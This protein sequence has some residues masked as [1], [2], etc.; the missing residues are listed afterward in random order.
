MNQSGNYEMDLTKKESKPR[1][2]KQEEDK[3][4]RL[5]EKYRNLTEK[6]ESME[7]DIVLI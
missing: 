3:Y 6:F 7:G 1:K 5:Y 2:Q 4:F